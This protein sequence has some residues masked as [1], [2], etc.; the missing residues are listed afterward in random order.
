MQSNWQER[1]IDFEQNMEPQTYHRKMLTEYSAYLLL[2]MNDD[3]FLQLIWY[4]NGILYAASFYQ[5]NT[6]HDICT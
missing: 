4:K 3:V 6:S 1:K 2:M 5:Y